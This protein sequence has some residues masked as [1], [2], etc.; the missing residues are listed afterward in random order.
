MANR[1]GQPAES[2]EPQA[3]QRL[4]DDL[5]ALY[6]AEV[7][8]PPHVD[9]AIAARARQRFVGLRRSR[10]VLRLVEVGAAAAAIL[11]VFWLVDFGPQP[12]Q[13]GPATAR[14]AD[15]H[16]LDGN[17]RVNIL[18]AFVLARHVESA[19]VPRSEW[20]LNGDGLVDRQD[21]D[22]V[23]MAAVTLDGRSYQ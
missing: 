12:Q 11:L 3:P 4:I 14:A 6:G 1:D 19:A 23:A 21:V 18:D 10:L 16:D 17:G 5:A 20:D 22:A 2:P 15:K 7:P 13:P 9:E 8:V